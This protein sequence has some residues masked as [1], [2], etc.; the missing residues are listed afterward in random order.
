MRCSRKSYGRCAAHLNGF[1]KIVRRALQ[2]ILNGMPRTLTDLSFFYS[3][4]GS[5]I[6]IVKEFN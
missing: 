6:E 5:N 2:R 3:M 4:S 1:L